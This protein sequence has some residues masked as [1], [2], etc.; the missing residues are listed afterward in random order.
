MVLRVRLFLPTVIQA[1]RTL[2]SVFHFLLLFFCGFRCLR[3]GSCR[4]FFPRDNA[5][6]STY[7]RFLLWGVSP[8]VLPR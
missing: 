2:P 5:K 7:A 8:T 3:E 1:I 4:L 6:T